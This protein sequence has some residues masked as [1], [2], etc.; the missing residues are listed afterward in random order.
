MGLE[1]NVDLTG[2]EV[3]PDRATTLLLKVDVVRALLQTAGALAV[4]ALAVA[5]PSK[6]LL[7]FGAVLGLPFAQ[8]GGPP[9]PTWLPWA[10]LAH[11]LLTL[12]ALKGCFRVAPRS[13]TLRRRLGLL[14][15]GE[16]LFL[17]VGGQER[18]FLVTLWTGVIFVVLLRAGLLLSREVARVSGEEGLE[19][20]PSKPRL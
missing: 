6:P 10:L 13:M 14:A 8:E 1:R 20:D 17:G 16:V 5:G 9:V 7:W 3:K 11:G 15:V 2:I 19:L 12:L 4:P 18:A